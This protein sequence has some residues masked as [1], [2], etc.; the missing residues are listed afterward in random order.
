M[1]SCLHDLKEYECGLRMDEVSV[2]CLLYADD[3]IILA[4]SACEQQKMMSME[5]CEHEWPIEI[6]TKKNKLHKM[7]KAVDELYQFP[8]TV[9]EN[10]H[11]TK[12]ME[13]EKLTKERNSE[14]RLYFAISI[15]ST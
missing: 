11:Q 7:L 12:K 10:L 15:P 4:S 13:S 1:E 9:T 14:S 6:G 3:Q 8:E 5:D 2:K